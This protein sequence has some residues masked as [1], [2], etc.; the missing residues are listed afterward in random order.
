MWAL[1]GAVGSHGG[2]L[3]RGMGP[4]AQGFWS[5]ADGETLRRL[6][7]VDETFVRETLYSE[8]KA[9]VIKTH[10]VVKW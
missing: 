8:S 6:G 10:C 4:L 1:S 7:W 2:C 9:W 3:M 5:Q